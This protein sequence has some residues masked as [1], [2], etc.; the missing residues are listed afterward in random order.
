MARAETAISRPHKLGFLATLRSDGWWVEPAVVA[1]G[2]S[3]FLG[4]LTITAFIDG[5]HY[6]IGPYLSPVFEPK[7]HGPY[8]AWYSL[9]LY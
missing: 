2:L 5:W 8:D 1:V 3:V 4:Y 9:P 6:E 7:L